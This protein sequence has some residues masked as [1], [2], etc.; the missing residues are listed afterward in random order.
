MTDVIR[1]MQADASECDAAQG[2]LDELLRDE[3][4]T[5][6]TGESGANASADEGELACIERRIKRLAD[7]EKGLKE[8]RDKL[9]T[10]VL[11]S[12]EE[13]GVTQVR[14]DDVLLHINTQF[15]PLY[16]QGKEKAIRVLR[17]LGG[18]YALLAPVDIP[19]QK[20]STFLKEAAEQ[21]TPLP[22][23]FRGVIEATHKITITANVRNNGG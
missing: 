7:R 17:R 10:H 6:R 20:M 15:R 19:W 1:D 5:L 22:K 8:Q 14:V 2:S 3:W 11:W 16:P 18:D 9:R 21:K 23:G 4:M 12:W 13:R